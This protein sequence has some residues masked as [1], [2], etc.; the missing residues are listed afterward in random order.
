MNAEIYD[1]NRLNSE[2]NRFA[3]EV[4]KTAADH[5]FWNTPHKLG[6]FSNL[7]F[8]SSIALIGT[9]LSEALE[10]FRKGEDDSAVAEEL[11]DAMIRI[12]DLAEAY[13]LDVVRAMIE[14]A[15]TNK[16]REY[17]HGKRF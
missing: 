15:E 16:G 13:K 10:S 8:S 12:F 3:F 1:K 5:G 14:K 6:Q 17:L 4:H 2:L 9:E 7:Q 11:A